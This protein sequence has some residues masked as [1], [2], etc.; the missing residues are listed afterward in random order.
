MSDIEG[1]C[2]LATVAVIDSNEGDAK[3]VTPPEIMESQLSTIQ[4]MSSAPNIDEERTAIIS[5]KALK[6]V[7]TAYLSTV[8]SQT[9]SYESR[10]LMTSYS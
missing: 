4:T 6:R 5:K 9:F 8:H 10:S 1:S 7:S 2:G 3:S